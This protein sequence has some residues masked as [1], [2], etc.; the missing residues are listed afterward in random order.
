MEGLRMILLTAIINEEE[1]GSVTIKF[2][3]QDI[4]EMTNLEGDIADKLRTAMIKARDEIFAN[5]DWTKY[6]LKEGYIRS[7]GSQKERDKRT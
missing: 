5:T 7:F 4:I 3:G 6:Q 1:N 2:S